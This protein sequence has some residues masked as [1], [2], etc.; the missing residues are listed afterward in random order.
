MTAFEE[1]CL[2]SCEKW[3]DSFPAEIPNHNFSNKH[4][5]KMVELFRQE[6]KD[7]V[8][9]LSKKT[10]KILLIAAILLALT[11]TT[12]FAIPA[13]RK[14]IVEKLSNH[15]EY[16]ILEKSKVKPV[17]SLTVNYVP[18]SFIKV[19]EDFNYQYYKN[20]ERHFVVEKSNINAGIGFDTETYDSENIEINGRE[21]VLY[22]S[23]NGYIGII[24][25]DSNYIFEISGNIEKEELVKIAQNVK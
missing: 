10:I 22:R 20:G 13:S 7:N 1:V 12:V 14:A 19:D 18:E 3:V 23:L 9:K 17:K 24:F 16:E 5:E 11:A 25:N 4:N 2:L 21:A 6:P 15:S 8:H